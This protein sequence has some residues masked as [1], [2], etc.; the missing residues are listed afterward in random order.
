MLRER[1]KTFRNRQMEKHIVDF[2]ASFFV[3]HIY[4]Y[5]ENPSVI[6]K[7]LGLVLKRNEMKTMEW[8]NIIYRWGFR[9]MNAKLVRFVLSITNRCGEWRKCII[10]NLT[11]RYT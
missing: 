8:I 4:I 2:F 5:T 6:E 7:N 9:K 3:L 11:L 1:K 10:G